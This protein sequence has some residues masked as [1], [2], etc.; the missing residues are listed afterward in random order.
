MKDRMVQIFLFLTL[1]LSF[2]FAGCS[3]STAQ[4]LAAMK[5]AG[6]SRPETVVDTHVIEPSEPTSPL[7]RAF[8]WE[9]MP[10]EWLS[11]SSK[12]PLLDAYQQHD[13][14]PIFINAGF[15]LSQDGMLVLAKL[16]QAED[17]ALEIRSFQLDKLN[18]YVHRLDQCRA[19][20]RT[21]DPAAMDRMARLPEMGSFSYEEGTRNPVLPVQVAMENPQTLQALPSSNREM[22]QRYRDT[23]RA[24]SQ[25]DLLL[26][27]Q[28]LRYS[29]L[30]NPFSKEMQ[31]E[32]LTHRMP[33]AEF[34]G[35][36]VPTSPHYGAL[37]I[38][39]KKYRS[40]AQ[41]HPN[42]PRIGTTGLRPGDSGPQVRDLQLRLQQE[43]F[44]PGKAHGTFD[45]NTQK[46]V[47]SFQVAHQ[48]NPD[49]AVGKATVDWLNVSYAQK[50]R[51]IAV[52]MRTLCESQTRQY[53]KYVRIN[54]PQ[55]KLEY[56]R[57]GKIQDVHRVIVGKAS[58]KRVKMQG[59]IMGE[60]QTPP[61][62]STIEQ[63]IV[64]PRW[65][66]TDRIY[67]ELAGD[68][69]ADPSFF[70][71]HGYVQ[72]SSVYSSGAPRVFQQ[73]GPTNPLGQV[74]FEFPNA[75]A[76]F[77]HDTPKKH[78]F[79]RSRRDFSHGCVRVEGA[80]KLAETLLADDQNPATDKM[81]AYLK[82]RNPT[83]IKLNQPIPIVIEYVT[84]ST[85]DHNSIVF[86]NDVYGVFA[87]NKQ[88]SS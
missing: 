70:A 33:M 79:S 85:G 36:L 56:I 5:D 16:R 62:A 18:Q 3:Q 71:R 54:I 75:Y 32:A 38:A 60:N 46:A 48:L 17:H 37:Q 41:D 4:S 40:L 57:D 1:A 20:L 12:Q 13:W 74:K 8:L 26:T 63:V 81:E 78:L 44:Y 80:R 51:M 21:L 45:A 7:W 27:Q 9:S 39:L 69:S 55:F 19:A 43:G 31:L 76:V 72:M 67:R 59:R 88:S 73:P 15:E 2:L 29:N 35:Q 87:E 10:T 24:A 58:G 53:D 14:Q 61:L 84:V 86:C 6:P 30:M 52:S 65:Y 77:L 22:E 83:H 50:A 47:Q 66:V 82:G 42:Q 34:L 64:N 23:F 25:A 49:G 68:V 28:F 11:D